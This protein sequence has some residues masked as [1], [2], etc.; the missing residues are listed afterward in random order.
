M[1]SLH[2]TASIPLAI[3]GMGCRLPGA[4]NLDQYWS[5]VSEGRS[6]VVE[7]PAERLDQELYYDPQVGVRGKTYSRLGAIISNRDFDRQACPIPEPLIESSDMTHLLMCEVAAAACRHAGMDPFHLSLRNTGVYIGHAQGSHLAGDYTYATC[8]AEGAEFLREVD[9]FQT[10]SVDQQQAVIKELVDRV[11]SQLPQRSPDTPDVAASMVAGLITKAFG[12]TGPYVAINSACASSLQAMLLGARALQRGYI[13]MAIVGGASDCK[14]DSL[15][16]FSAARAMSATGTRPFDANA[17]GL[18]TGEGYVALVMKTLERA[19]ADGDPIQ[20]VVRGLGVSSDGKGKS[21]WAPR[22]EGQIKAMQRAYRTGIEMSELQYIEAHATATQLGDATELNTLIELLSDK[23]PPGRKI[24][25][26]S[27]KANIGHSLETAGIAGVIKTVLSMQHETVP[28]AINIQQRNPKIDWEG[29]PIFIPQTPIPWPAPEGGKPRR[30]GVNA[31]GIG[32]LNMHVVLDQFIS[33]TQAPPQQPDGRANAPASLQPSQDNDLVAV[34][35]MGCVLPGASNVAEFW[36]LLLSGRDAKSHATL[37]RW[38]TDLAYRPGQP[39]PYSSPQTLGGFITDFHYD[40]RTHKVPPK[41]IEQAD[42]LQFMLLDAADQAMNDAGYDRKEFD[43][44]RLGVVVG[45][46]FGGDFQFQLQLGLRLPHMCQILQQLLAR[47]NV[48]PDTITAIGNKFA[49]VLLKHWP[50]LIDETGSFSTSTLASRIAK[51]FNV[52][53]GA[54]AIDSGDAS[55]LSA[56]SICVDMLLTGDCDMMLCAAGQRRMGLPAFEALSAAGMLATDPS[57]HGPFD[58]QANGI[59][60]GEAVGVLLLKR[61]SDARRDGD[62]IHAIVRGIGAA[63]DPAW[64]EALRAAIRR[65]LGDAHAPA[66]DIATLTT[67]GVGLTSTDGEI[68]QAVLDVYGPARQAAPLLL[69]SLVGQMGHTGGASGM[70]SLIASILAVQEGKLPANWGLQHPLPSIAAHPTQLATPSQ[71][72]AIR[73]ATADHRR[74]AA[75][76]S[77]SKGMDYQVVLERSEKVPRDMLDTPSSTR[78]K[79][80]AAPVTPPPVPAVTAAGEAGTDSRICRI[81]TVSNEQMAARLA[82]AQRDINSLWNGARGHRFDPHLPCRLAIVADGPHWLEKKLK[83][84][85]SQMGNP[86]AADVL[87]QQGIFFRQTRSARPQV[88]FLFAGQGSQ[89]SGMLRPL[90]QTCPAAAGAL[91]TADA[92]MRRAGLPAFSQL[93]WQ[94]PNAL[95]TDPFATQISILL[96]DFV[97]AAA[98]ADL[99]IHPDLVAG[100]SYGEYAALLVTGAWDLDTAIRVTRARCDGIAACAQANGGMV[101]TDASSEVVEQSIRQSCLPVYLANHN[102]PQQTVV[103]GPNDELE[104]LVRLLETQNFSA[105]FL[106]VPCPFHTPLMAKAVGPLSEALRAANIKMPNVPLYSVATNRPVASVEEIRDN[107][108]A[109][110]TTPVRYVDL[111]EKLV[112]PN[113]TILVEVGPQQ[114]LTRLHRQILSGRQ[115]ATVAS[116]NPKAPGLQQLLHVQAVL[117][118]AGAGDPVASPSLQRPTSSKEESAAMPEPRHEII[119]FDATESRRASKRSTALGQQGGVMPM[120]PTAAPA[121]KQPATPKVAGTPVGN[122]QQSPQGLV[123]PGSRQVVPPGRPPLPQTPPGGR[124]M[125]PTTSAAQ[126]AAVPAAAPP[127]PPPPP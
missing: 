60:P 48:A 52:M 49:D 57:P 61:L 115:V 37:D 84:A 59:L 22:K 64:D 110:M 91:Q 19:L 15:V 26:T 100:H 40:W 12:L 45:T 92:A 41:Q 78:S 73:H 99:G 38:R 3:V 8:V 83:V 93:C 81:A 6:A 114:A 35:G 87:Q 104:N 43:R 107:L 102:A 85:A 46:E 70:V 68:I 79:P 30:A 36:E 71:T 47:R 80:V 75:V 5:L 82:D 101:V 116:D 25:I 89:Y 86:A 113:E 18:I 69:N 9:D 42:P 4:D 76:V 23:V 2:Q 66:S 58:A 13:D 51:S 98:L 122:H 72:M 94:E 108:V 120:T 55:A 50:A 125:T 44:A 32:G 63:Y 7:L 97:M 109:H 95:G 67:D 118:C 123:P 24:P 54:A 10:L 21:L 53:G 1:E 105:R 96:A 124:R 117:E 119:H 106:P 126:P 14:G 112:A 77:C 88:A 56:L 127:P 27:V 111:I 31:F 39:A 33:T 103:G 17:D 121:E 16:L 65:S 11:R 74:L 20:A 34:I 62:T 28:P 90:V 29:A